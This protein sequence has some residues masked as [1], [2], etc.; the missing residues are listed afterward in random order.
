MSCTHWRVMVFATIPMAPWRIETEPF[1][2]FGYEGDGGAGDE[3]IA[4]VRDGRKTVSVSLS[5]EWDLEGGPPRVGQFFMIIDP[6]RFAGDGFGE[7]VEALCQAML[8]E[9]GTRVPGERRLA[10]R[11]KAAE[12][13]VEIP[14]A[15]HAELVKRA[16]A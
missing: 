14:D 15:L 3:R 7:R 10:L 12:Q 9:P 13:G 1:L 4:K 11:A 6:Q 2:E 8:S 16:G 5:R